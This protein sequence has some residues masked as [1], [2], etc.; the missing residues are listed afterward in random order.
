[1]PVV[2]FFSL[3][4][5]FVTG[6]VG[7]GVYF[8]KRAQQEMAKRLQKED[9]LAVKEALENEID[10]ADLRAKAVEAGLDP[11]EVLSGYEK[12]RDSIITPEQVLKAL[13]P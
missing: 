4:G 12:L 13:E 3:A 1:M 6:G 10:L 8:F 7:G 5:A 2:I 9:L 11:D